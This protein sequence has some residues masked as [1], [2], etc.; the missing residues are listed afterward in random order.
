MTSLWLFLSDL[1]VASFSFYDM[2]GNVL[3]WIFFIVCCV[4]FVYWCWVLV[5]PLGGDKDLEYKS[6]SKEKRPYYDPKIM[7]KG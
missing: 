2:F 6:P 7:K 5:V 4:L 3:N 1:F